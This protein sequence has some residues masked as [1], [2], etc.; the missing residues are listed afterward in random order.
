MKIRVQSLRMVQRT[1]TTVKATTTPTTV[2][3]EVCPLTFIVVGGIQMQQIHAMKQNDRRVA[4]CIGKK[5]RWAVLSRRADNV[6]G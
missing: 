2:S 4:E 1:A 3:P 5:P 6:C